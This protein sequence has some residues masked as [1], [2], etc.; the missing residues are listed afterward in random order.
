ME[1][2][3]TFFDLIVDVFNETKNPMMADEIWEKK[4]W[5]LDLIKS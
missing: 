5:N 4:P 3:Y 1:K 2:Q